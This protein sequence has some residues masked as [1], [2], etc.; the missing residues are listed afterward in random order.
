[1]PSPV[2]HVLGGVA[3]AWIADLVPGPRAWRTAPAGASWSARAGGG[4]TAACAALAMAPDLDLLIRTH[5]AVTHSTAAVALAGLLGAALAARARWPVARVSLMCA[6]AYAT[7]LLFDWMAVD[8]YAPNGIQALWPFS[9]A[10]Y[11][12]GW[13]IFRQTERARLLT[14]ASIQTNVLALAQEMAILAPIVVS[15]WLV[16]VKTLAGLSAQLAR[17][18]HPPE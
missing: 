17:G 8:R 10:F 6:V 15:V 12:S 4:L 11:L 9:S 2:G 13:N 7:H 5:R 14:V 3:A 1:M 16:R 18:D